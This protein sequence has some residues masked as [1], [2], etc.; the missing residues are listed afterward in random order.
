MQ[1][2]IYLVTLII[3]FLVAYIDNKSKIIPDKI[4]LIIALLGIINLILD[5][6]NCKT[7]IASTAITFAAFLLLAII[8]DGAIGGG[9]VKLFTALAL[10]FGTEIMLI[11]AVTFTV[12]AIINITKVIFKRINI[13]DSVALAPYICAGT[14]LCLL[15][16]L[17]MS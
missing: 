1:N 9:D 13:K 5:F 11:I 14:I 17:Y 12:A 4:N 3:L 10:I 2:L 7:Y 8:T 15:K 16:N 6:H